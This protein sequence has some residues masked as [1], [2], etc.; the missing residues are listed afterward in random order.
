MSAY[1]DALCAIVKRMEQQLE[2]CLAKDAK[3]PPV[4]SQRDYEIRAAML[5]CSG[6]IVSGPG[7]SRQSPGLCGVPAPQE[8]FV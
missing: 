8:S 5:H 1:I 4:Q 7:G 3:A 2:E 6:D